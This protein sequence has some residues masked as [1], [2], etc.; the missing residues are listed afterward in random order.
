[1][2]AVTTMSFARIHRDNLINFGILPLI[3]VNKSD[4][5]N[6]ECNNTLEIKGIRKILTDNEQ[7]IKIK[8]LSKNFIFEA[9]HDLSDRE[10]N[11]ILSGGK[12]NYT[13]NL[14]YI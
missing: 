2:E 11:V 4:Y 13:K 8:N 7:K 6:L 5:N 12:L 3:F 14:V 9:T 1:M 10:R